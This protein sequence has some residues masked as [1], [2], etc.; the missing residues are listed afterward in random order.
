ME[1]LREKWPHTL[2]LDFEPEG[3]FV[4][5]AADPGRLV[6][7]ADPAEICEL[8]VEF[9]TGGPADRRQ[10][11]VLRDVVEAVQHGEAGDA[12][13]ADPLHAHAARAA[14]DLADAASVDEW[15]ANAGRDDWQLDAD[16]AFPKRG[17]NPAAA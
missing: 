2:V 1:R 10:L 3:E 16:L 13:P 15:L 4:S 6:K 17:G 11:A 7:A 8:F 5:A 12:A 14:A 9:T